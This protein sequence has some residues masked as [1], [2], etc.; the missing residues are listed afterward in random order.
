MSK[1]KQKNPQEIFFPVP[2]DVR[3]GVEKPPIS[4]AVIESIIRK[5]LVGA[6]RLR[7][8]YQ[9]EVE[10]E[11]FKQV[12]TQE[13]IDMVVH[14]IESLQ[15]TDAIE[16]ALASQ[17]VITYVR[18]LEGS[19]KDTNSS[20]HMMKMFE[21]GHRVLDTMQRYKNKGAQQISVQYNVN[22]GQVFNV[23]SEKGEVI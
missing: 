20:D 18:A 17:F 6:F 9:Y 3:V 4:R 8:P 7:E 11:G 23:Q 15:P 2:K 12:A 21:F 1:R 16:A 5:S 22:Q 10:R 13:Q 19:T 14:L